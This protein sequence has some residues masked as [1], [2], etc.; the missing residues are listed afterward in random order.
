MSAYGTVVGDAKSSPVRVSSAPNLAD[1]SDQP[2]VSP[3]S[4]D[5]W[6]ELEN[7]IYEENDN[8][9]DGWDDL[10]PLEEANASSALAN[11]QAAQKRPVTLPKQGIF[12]IHP[13][14]NN[15]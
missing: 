8:D 7:G 13:S 10:E 6:G 14:V 9:K 12:I 1:F 4:A 5:G 15:L 2:R 3:T 11:I